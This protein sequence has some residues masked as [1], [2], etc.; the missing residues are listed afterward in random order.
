[1]FP[2]T[3]QQLRSMTDAARSDIWDLARQYGREPKIYLHWTA[4]HYDQLFPEYHINIT[5]SG[6]IYA[7]T[8]DLS[9]ILSHTYRRNT[10]AVGVTLCCC[11]GADTTD[12]GDEP[13][14]Y[15][16]LWAIGRVITCIA[17]GLWVT[18]DKAH[19]MTHGEA[20]DNEDGIYPHE[21]YGP[22]TTCERWDLEYLG[23]ASSPAFTPYGTARGGDIL[24]GIANWHRA[25][26]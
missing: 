11:F 14:T 24:R 2:I 13:P 25:R 21:E 9:D 16:Q 3:E 12:L 26:Q 5:G 23:T 1:M 10:G 6:A 7:A 15:E 17:D 22:K 4:G 8:D 19:V 18:I 20:A